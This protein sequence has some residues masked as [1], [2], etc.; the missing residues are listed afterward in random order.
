[1][2]KK[3][4]GGVISK[5]AHAISD[6][7]TGHNNED[8]TPQADSGDTEEQEKVSQDG[9]SLETHNTELS[10]ADEQKID[11]IFGKPKQTSSYNPSEIQSHSKFD[12][13]K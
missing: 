12:K 4:S 1:M 8:S 7:L 2:A 9:A 5:A 11:E 10:Q 3:K 13:F 6:A